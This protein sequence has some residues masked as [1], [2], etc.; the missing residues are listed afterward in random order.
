MA[1]RFELI[2]GLQAK[3]AL[4]EAA[5]TGIDALRQR[6]VAL[7]TANVAWAKRCAGLERRVRELEAENAELKK[8]NA[9]L[10]TENQALRAENA[11]L[12]R[13]LGLD[14]ANSE[15]TTKRSKEPNDMT[16]QK[17]F[18]EETGEENYPLGEF[19]PPCFTLAISDIARKLF[20][21]TANEPGRNGKAVKALTELLDALVPENDEK[22]GRGKNEPIV[23]VVETTEPV[24]EIVIKAGAIEAVVTPTEAAFRLLVSAAAKFGLDEDGAVALVRTFGPIVLPKYFNRDGSYGEHDEAHIVRRLKRLLAK[25]SP[26][27]APVETEHGTWTFDAYIDEWTMLD[28]KGKPAFGRDEFGCNRVYRRAEVEPGTGKTRFKLGGRDALELLNAVPTRLCDRKTYD[29]LRHGIVGSVSVEERSPE[30]VID[31][32]DVHFVRLDE[33]TIVVIVVDHSAEAA[34]RVDTFGSVREVPGKDGRNIAAFQTENHARFR[35]RNHPTLSSAIFDAF[36]K[37]PVISIE[38]LNGLGNVAKFV[39]NDGAVLQLHDRK[40]IEAKP[41]RKRNPS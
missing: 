16:C 17:D 22:N 21:A 14:S 30:I 25:T 5:P 11:A 3:V 4:L 13:R 41:S 24:R 2:A 26:A 34:G 7:E 8:E 10:R 12:R 27:L 32:F 20:I 15:T 31:D 33:K 23:S 18:R 29:W 39:R 9:E 38:K 36:P 28:E 37:L 40:P 19:P 35:L 6:I 1:Q